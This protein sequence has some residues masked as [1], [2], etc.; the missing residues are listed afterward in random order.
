MVTVP[1]FAFEYLAEAMAAYL[2]DGQIVVLHP[3]GTGG[4]LEIRRVWREIGLSTKVLL[5]CT[6]TLR[7]CRPSAQARSGRH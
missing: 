3:G 6:E 2:V 1:G 7:V 5:G 4:A